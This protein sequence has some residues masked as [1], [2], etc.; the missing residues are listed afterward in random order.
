MRYVAA[1][2][3]A[4]PARTGRKRRAMRGGHP[5]IAVSVAR[6]PAPGAVAGRVDLHAHHP[7]RPGPCRAVINVLRHD[8]PRLARYASIFTVEREATHSRCPGRAR[9]AAPAGPACSADVDAVAAFIDRRHAPTQARRGSGCHPWHSPATCAV[10]PFTARWTT[11]SCSRAGSFN[12]SMLH[13]SARCTSV[14]VNVYSGPG[15]TRGKGS[16][17]VGKRHAGDG[18]RH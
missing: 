1:S 13:L 3:A 16:G 11:R 2:C 15:A 14:L 6:Q 5:L 7:R 17:G 9:I 4:S 10:E 18:S 8:L 12:G